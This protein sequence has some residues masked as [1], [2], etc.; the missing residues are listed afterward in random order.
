MQTKEILKN[1]RKS[2]GYSVKQVADG[3]GM[4]PGVYKKYESGERGVGTPAL[5]KLAKFYGVT[6]DYLLGLEERKNPIEA[7]ASMFK[8]SNSS[9]ALLAAY[10]YMEEKDRANL[11][12]AVQKL[13]NP[14]DKKEE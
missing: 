5:C 9:K 11:L 14:I 13:A 4:S 12:E 1:L 3:C 2:N 10:L 6:T 7:I 8:L